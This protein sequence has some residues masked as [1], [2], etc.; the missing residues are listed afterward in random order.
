MLTEV[1]DYFGHGHKS[2]S[3][4]R[5]PFYTQISLILMGLWSC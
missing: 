2:S 4:R 3:P 5:T 1:I